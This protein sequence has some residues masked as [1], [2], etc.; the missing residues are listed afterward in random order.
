MDEETAPVDVA[1]KIVAE[2]RALACALDDA[3]NVR[4]HEGSALG[5]IDDA[6]IGGEGRKMIVRDLR[7][8]AGNAREQRGFAD[9]RETDK[10]DVRKQF[11]LQNKLMALAGHTGLGKARHLTRRRGEMLVAPAAAPA[12]CGDERL[13]RRHIGH[14]AAGGLV[15]HKRAARHADRDVRTVLAGAAFVETVFSVGCGKLALI[16]EIHQRGHMI[17]HNEDDVAAAPTVAA[18]RPACRDKLFAVE[19]DGAVAAFAGVYADGDF[20]YKS[21]AH[22]CSTCL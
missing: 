9:V 15:A 19:G 12:P 13:A 8:R 7:P 3:G 18:V 17:V 11:K 1:E 5:N 21:V 16:A 22:A 6:E 10:S 2:T 20:I 14:D 4:Q